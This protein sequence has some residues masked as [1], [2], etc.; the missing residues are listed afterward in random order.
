M[1]FLFTCSTKE[2]KGC[3]PVLNVP[4]IILTLYL[5]HGIIKCNSTLKYVKIVSCSLDLLRYLRIFGIVNNK[6]N[7]EKEKS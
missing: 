4:T 5:L 6:K 3:I 2:Q 7:E 1:V